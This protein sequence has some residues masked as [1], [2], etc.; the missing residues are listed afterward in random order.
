[1]TQM[2]SASAS[3]NTWR[4]RLHFSLLHSSPPFPSCLF[5]DQPWQTFARLPYPPLQLL[6]RR[7]PRR[8]PLLQLLR[9]RRR[10]SPA[11][12]ESIGASLSLPLKIIRPPSSPIA[13]VSQNYDPIPRTH[14]TAS[15]DL[16]EAIR[17]PRV[18]KA[19]P[20]WTIETLVPY[21]PVDRA[22]SKAYGPMLL[23]R[24]SRCRGRPEI[25]ATRD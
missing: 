19:R 13:R 10:R 20:C 14:G 8:R 23:S 18:L 4:R 6:P 15:T 7:C 16:V 24:I 22:F 25:E 21:K 2:P 11:R 5:L 1:M 9:K 12:R 3:K 17:A